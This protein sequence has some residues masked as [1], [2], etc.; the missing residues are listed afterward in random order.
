[1]NINIDNNYSIYIRYFIKFVNTYISRLAKII[2]LASTSNLTMKI[3]RI[4]ICCSNSS[5]SC[6]WKIQQRVTCT[7]D[8]SEFLSNALSFCVFSRKDSTCWI[9]SWDTAF[10]RASLSV[11]WPTNLF[12]SLGFHV[13]IM[14]YMKLACCYTHHSVSSLNWLHT[15]NS[16]SVTF[17]SSP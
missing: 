1:M 3:C 7:K 4:I 15:S 8:F 11:C 16:A 6:E 12:Y 5:R 2:V 14:P 10:V 9:C 13:Y 17:S